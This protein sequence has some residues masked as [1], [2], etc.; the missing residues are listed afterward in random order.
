MDFRDS[1]IPE[2][3]DSAIPTV[4]DTVTLIMLLFRDF[5]IFVFLRV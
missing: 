4:D 1:K 3:Q 2:L 5:K